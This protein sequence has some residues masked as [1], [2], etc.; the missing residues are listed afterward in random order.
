MDEIKELVSKGQKS[1]D[2]GDFNAAL[3]YFEQALLL[4]QDDPDLWNHKGV[5][6]RSLGRYEESMECFNKSLEIDPRDKHAS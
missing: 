6:L 5:A 1:L 2:D 3:G 4:N